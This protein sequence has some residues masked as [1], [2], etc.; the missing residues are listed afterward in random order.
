MK[1]FYNNKWGLN[2]HIKEE[3]ISGDDQYGEEGLWKRILKKP[4]R[5]KE[6]VREYVDYPSKME[7]A[8]YFQKEKFKTKFSI[9][10][11]NQCLQKIILK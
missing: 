5:L 4:C 1:E 8:L 11:L 7:F 9:G 3:A 6:N 10:N 2:K